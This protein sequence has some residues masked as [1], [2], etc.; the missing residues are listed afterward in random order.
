MTTVPGSRRLSLIA[1]FTALAIILNFAISFPAPFADFLLYEVWEVP[2]VVAFLLLGLRSGVTVAFLNSIVLELVKPGAL[3]TGPV[4]NFAAVL[5]MFAG[6]LLAQRAAK[7]RGWG[8][9]TLI[10]V[11]T[12]LGVATRTAIMTIVNAIVLPLPYPVGFGSFGVTSS[13]VPALLVLIG[14]FNVTVALYTIPLSY[15]LQRGIAARYRL[16][17]SHAAT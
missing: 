15:S 7:G 10:T 14:L 13:Q 12:S 3:P 8:I 4:Y 11:S 9:V 17:L 6:M 2:I 16:D 5:A 1:L